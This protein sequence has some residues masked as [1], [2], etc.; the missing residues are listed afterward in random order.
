MATVGQAGWFGTVAMLP[1]SPPVPAQPPVEPTLSHRAPETPPARRPWWPKPTRK[2]SAKLRSIS[3]QFSRRSLAK[4][5][6]T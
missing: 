3:S 4:A 5:F 2:K 1:R 6:A